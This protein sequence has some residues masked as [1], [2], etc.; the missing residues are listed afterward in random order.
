MCSSDLI[1]PPGN[2]Y[3]FTE[4]KS[5]F[6][7]ITMDESSGN[8][9]KNLYV[10]DS[11][12]AVIVRLKAASRMRQGDSLRISLKGAT[13]RYY[14]NLFQ[15]DSVD[16]KNLI[17]Q[18]SGLNI[19]PIPVTI[20]ELKLANFSTEMQS[21]LIKLENVQFIATDTTKTYADPIN[22]IS[23]NRTLVDDQGNQILVRTSG[24]AS[25]AGAKVPNGSGSVIAIVSQFRED[26]QLVIRKLS[27][28]DLNGERF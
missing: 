4:D 20:P 28:V 26:R 9:Y 10:Q 19:E 14:E 17:L 27:E 25:F 6:A 15:V 3:K 11:S 5:F 24:F 13:L 7:I 8:I 18:K 2:V 1:C 23:E 21:K 22:Q 12:Q 16:I